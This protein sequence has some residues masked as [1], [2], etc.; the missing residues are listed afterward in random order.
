MSPVLRRVRR[1][2]RPGRSGLRRGG[3]AHRR[4]GRDDPRPGRGPRARRRGGVPPHRREPGGD[5]ARLAADGRRA[6]RARGEHAREGAHRGVPLQ[7]PARVQHAHG[8]FHHPGQLP[9]GRPQRARRAALRGAVLEHGV[10]RRG[11]REPDRRR[12]AVR[13]GL[14]RALGGHGEHPALPRRLPRRSA[15]RR[16]LR[17]GGPGRR[18]RVRGAGGVGGRARLPAVP[19]DLRLAHPHRRDPR[20]VPEGDAAGRRAAAALRRP[21][22]G[23]RRDRGAD[24]RACGPGLPDGDVRRAQLRDP[25]PSGCW[26]RT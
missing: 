9:A 11:R 17:R 8:P 21:R 2:R 19:G 16:R 22:R 3:P 4:R 14:E 6:R 26:R 23:R 1:G 12:E 13:A 5:R 7:Q 20:R 24:R 25:R 15:G 18:R 10:R